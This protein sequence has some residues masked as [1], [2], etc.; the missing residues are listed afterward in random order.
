MRST[1]GD[2]CRFAMQRAPAGRQGRGS[3][4]S[5]KCLEVE[6]D[7]TIV[8]W[9]LCVDRGPATVISPKNARW[10][11]GSHVPPQSGASFAYGRGAGHDRT[12]AVRRGIGE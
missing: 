9:S 2:A 7:D 8:A 3:M 10:F 12:N 11:P 6:K 4:A 5:H 1:A